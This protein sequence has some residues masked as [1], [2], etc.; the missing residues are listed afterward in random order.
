VRHPD[1]FKSAGF[2]IN[3]DPFMKNLTI[4]LFIGICFLFFMPFFLVAAE[5]S[6]TVTLEWEPNT[7]PHL[8]GYKVFCRNVDQSYIYAQPIWEGK[9]PTCTLASLEYHTSYYFVVRAYG[10]N[11]EESGNSNEVFYSTGA[12]ETDDGLLSSENQILSDEWFSEQEPLPPNDSTASDQDTSSNDVPPLVTDSIENRPPDQPVIFY[13]EDNA[14][15]VLL[16]PE[17]ISGVFIDQD[18]ADLHIKSQWRIIK[19]ENDICV[20]DMT[21]DKRLTELIVPALIMEE[22]SVYFWSVRFFD[23]HGNVSEWAIPHSFRTSRLTQDVENPPTATEGSEL[24][25]GQ[26]TSG[27]LD[28]VNTPVTDDDQTSVTE[29]QET[30]LPENSGTNRIIIVN[31]ATGQGQIRINLDEC[32]HVRS[33]DRINTIDP[34]TISSTSNTPDKMTMGLILFKLSLEQPGVTALIPMHF[35]QQMPT[36]VKWI[37]YD[38]VVGWQDYSDH[39]TFTN[40]RMSVILEIKDGGFGDADGAENGIIVDPSGFGIASPEFYL[41]QAA[42]SGAGASATE[43]GCF[44]HTVQMLPGKK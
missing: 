41:N 25:L 31:A 28:A 34:D 44:I 32:T 39:S 29:N 21:T 15:D 12:P 9:T 4:Y 3:R 20:F 14:L 2:D 5:A 35:S 33:I 26:E 17:L 1:L 16:E 37:K 38:S 22:D 43:S 40:N 42:N 7:E 23:N 30:N 19:K 11:G 6:T 18:S 24:E 10:F 36:D 13:P 8:D 27:E